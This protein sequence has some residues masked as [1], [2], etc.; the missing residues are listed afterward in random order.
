[1][2]P[3]D[4]LD[5]R[6]AI[7]DRKGKAIIP[8][9]KNAR[10]QR[11]IRFPAL[12]ERDRAI[13]RIQELGAEGRSQW[14]QE[15]GYHRRSR[16]ETCMYRYKTA[17]GERLSSRRPWTQTTEMAIKLDAMNRMTELGMPK[18]YKVTN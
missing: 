11:K 10:L 7:H 2:G 13:R 17:F 5:C 4:T 12:E 14:K 9:D 8:P 6:E 3:Y 16:V 15:I 1:M 18:I